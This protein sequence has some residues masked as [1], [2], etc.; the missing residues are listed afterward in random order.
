[1]SWIVGQLL[2][3]D[4][5]PRAGAEQRF[6]YLFR[7]RSPVVGFPALLPGR[8]RLLHGEPIPL[9]LGGELDD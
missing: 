5:P 9:P 2:R 4:R 6:R 3:R 8:R 1:M 7:G